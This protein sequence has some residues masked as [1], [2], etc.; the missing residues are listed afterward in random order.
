[1]TTLKEVRQILRRIDR[2]NAH[3]N[4]RQKS[5]LKSKWKTTMAKRKSK[6]NPKRDWILAQTCKTGKSKRSNWGFGKK[7]LHPDRPPLKKRSFRVNS[8]LSFRHTLISINGLVAHSDKH[9]THISGWYAKKEHVD[10]EFTRMMWHRPRVLGWCYNGVNVT[11]IIN[12]IWCGKK[13]WQLKKTTLLSQPQQPRQPCQPCHHHQM[14]S[15]QFAPS[16]PP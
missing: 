7:K 10:F 15:F 16:L 5:F 1:M 6:E 2:A 4:K 11:L 14:P 13:P 9:K 12:I 3:I 8:I